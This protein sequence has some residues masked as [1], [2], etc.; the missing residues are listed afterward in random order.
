MKR[1][2]NIIPVKNPNRKGFGIHSGNITEKP[3]VFLCFHSKMLK[4]HVFSCVVA[5]KCCKTMCFIVFSLPNVAK[6]LFLLC[7]LGLGLKKPYKTYQKVGFSLPNVAKT[8]F[9]LC[10]LTLGI[11][12]WKKHLFFQ[13]KTF[14]PCKTISKFGLLGKNPIE[15][16]LAFAIGGRLTMNLLH[17]LC[18]FLCIPLFDCKMRT[19]I[20][21]RP[22]LG[23]KK[24]VKKT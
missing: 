21:L 18:V 1:K 10:F 14:R 7:L 22:L 6:T 19:L 9:L 8:R 4:N 16:D 17:A 15:S 2:H 3:C 20:V 13:R 24:N 11:K 12:K 5:P 23:K